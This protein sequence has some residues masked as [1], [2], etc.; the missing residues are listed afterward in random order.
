VTTLNPY[1]SFGSTAREAMTFYQEVLGGDLALS[2]FGEFGMADDAPAADQIMHARLET[3]SGLNL[4]AA[5]TPPG[6]ET[7]PMGGFA[8]S[9]SGEDESELRG[10]WDKLVDG[11]SI[12]V[13]LE[14]QMWGDTFGQ[15]VD[16][17]G[18]S[19]MVNITGAAQE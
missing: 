3:A 10:Y 19:W 13:P 16:R 8:I 1:L 2:T 5:D 6:M 17:F 14:K 18:V 11:G 4:M 7:S 9:L 12:V 15:L